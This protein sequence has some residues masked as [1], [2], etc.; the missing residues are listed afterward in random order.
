[1]SGV[2]AGAET[3]QKSNRRSPSLTT[4]TATA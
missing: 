1:M 4:Q 3:T 2:V